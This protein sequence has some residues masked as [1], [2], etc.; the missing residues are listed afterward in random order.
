[1]A[2][3]QRASRPTLQSARNRGLTEAILE[4]A[5]ARPPRADVK[6]AWRGG[7]LLLV[8]ERPSRPLRAAQPQLREGPLLRRRLDHVRAREGG[9]APGIEARRPHGAARWDR[10]F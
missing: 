7:R 10:A 4:S 5:C 3:S 9:P 8:V 6:A 2:R 1:M